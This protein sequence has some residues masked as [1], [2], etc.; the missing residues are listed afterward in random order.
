M[1]VM[2]FITHLRG[3][4][5]IY[6]KRERESEDQSESKRMGEHRKK[7]GKCQSNWLW[8]SLVESLRLS[9]VFL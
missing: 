8:L 2:V 9:S 4:I 3:P 5:F 1:V 7:L 6:I